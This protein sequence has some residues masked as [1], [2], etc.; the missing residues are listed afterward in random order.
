MSRERQA[1]PARPRH[2]GPDAGPVR[3]APGQ[4]GSRVPTRALLGGRA[5]ARGPLAGL[6][7]RRGSR[8]SVC[9]NLDTLKRLMA[10]GTGASAASRT[11]ASALRC[12]ASSRDSHRLLPHPRPTACRPRPRPNPPQPI[13]ALS[14]PQGLAWGPVPGRAL[15]WPHPL[16]NRRWGAPRGHSRM[17]TGQLRGHGG[18]VRSAVYPQTCRASARTT[19]KVAV[20]CWGLA[21]EAFRYAGRA[22][23]GED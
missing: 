2:G 10:T 17:P 1:L 12:T 8:A 14:G 16:A 21:L 22:F 23:P 9:R 20:F 19:D 5:V 15:L 18:H 13:G 4:A 3:G 6:T 11:R 7:S